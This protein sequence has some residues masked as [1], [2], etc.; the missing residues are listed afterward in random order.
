[1][2]AKYLRRR[3]GMDIE[4][5]EHMLRAQGGAC[6]ICRRPW[7]RCPRPKMTHLDQ[8]LF[9]HYLFVDHD[10]RTG[11]V[12][13]LLCNACNTAIGLFEERAERFVAAIEYIAHFS[14]LR[15]VPSSAGARK[16]EGRV[17]DVAFAASLFGAVVS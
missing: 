14:D 1:M 11:A 13:G 12:R 7:E 15:D 3:Y 5:L 9:L 17:R 8:G 16:G 6:A 10:H 2:R 4:R